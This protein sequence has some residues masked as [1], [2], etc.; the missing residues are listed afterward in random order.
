MVIGPH[1]LTTCEKD[2]ERGAASRGPTHSAARRSQRAVERCDGSERAPAFVAAALDGT[3]TR[4]TGYPACWPRRPLSPARLLAAACSLY[5]SA[6]ATAAVP[7]LG[8]PGIL[9]HRSHFEKSRRRTKGP[10]QPKLDGCA[11]RLC[12]PRRFGCAN[13]CAQ[14]N[15]ARDNVCATVIP[16]LHGD[17]MRTRCA[18]NILLP[19][20]P[21]ARR[22]AD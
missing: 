21:R 9:F 3:R 19:S 10:A 2:R 8:H 5:R 14:V 4:R 12:S 7:A 17:S 20:W 15:G 13:A 1:N 22:L 18:R 16:L 11:R 6:A